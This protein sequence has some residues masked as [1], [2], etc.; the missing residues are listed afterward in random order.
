MRKCLTD[1]SHWGI[2][3]TEAPSCLVI[4]A[5]VDTQNQPVHTKLSLIPLH[6][7]WNP[8]ANYSLS[9]P[10]PF[11]ASSHHH[12]A[13]S[14]LE[15]SIFS[16]HI[17]LRRWGFVFGVS[18]LSPLIWFLPTIGTDDGTGF[19]SFNGW[20]I[21]NTRLLLNFFIHAPINIC[22]HWLH[23]LPHFLSVKCNFCL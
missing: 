1:R 16:F 3:S 21:L 18:G 19:Y 11:L 12:S 4:L 6:T 9:L 22:L 13:L 5:C 8:L 23:I 17:G 20:I 14:C 15:I 2:P 10:P 7:C